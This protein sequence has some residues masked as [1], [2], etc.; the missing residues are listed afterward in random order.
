MLTPWET[1]QTKGQVNSVMQKPGVASKVVSHV[2]S[3]KLGED[4]NVIILGFLA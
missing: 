2:L 3:R 4:L 1:G